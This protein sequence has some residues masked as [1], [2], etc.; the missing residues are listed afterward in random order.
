[1]SYIL[2]LGAGF[3]RNWGGLLAFE[4]FN[5]LLAIP[6]IQADQTIRD[7]LWANQKSGGFENALAEIQRAYLQNPAA[8]GQK[9]SVLQQAVLDVFQGMNNAF[10]DMPGMEFQ[11]HQARMLRTFLVKFDAIFTLNQDILLDHHYLNDNIGLTAPQ[12]W[13][14]SAQLPGMQRIPS[15]QAFP[16]PSWG[17]DTWVPL[18]PEDFRIKEQSQPY[19]KLHGST[20]WRDTQGG[21]MLVIGGDKSQAIQSHQVLSRYFERFQDYLSKPNTKLMIIGY[22]FR[23]PHINQPIINAVHN[24]LRFFVIDQL[25]TEVVKR[26]NSSFGGAIYAP[27]ELDDAFHKGLSGASQRT[28]AET[29]GNDAVS[30]G[31]VMQFFA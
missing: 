7:V 2:L 3:S 4:V 23:D 19:F 10:L 22:G 11:Q 28:L 24:G 20:N 9:L 13:P 5:S 18:K 17:R 31:T 6:A 27:N 21:Q 14:N 16:P 1:M 25:G 30:H 8:T 15:Q 26:A 12:R 29:F